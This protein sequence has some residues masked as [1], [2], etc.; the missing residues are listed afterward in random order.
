MADGQDRADIIA[1]P[2]VIFAG[3]LVLGAVISQVWPVGVPVPGW[4]YWLAAP[5]VV[6]PLVIAA[7]AIRAL[8]RAK[9]EVDPRRPTSAIVRDGPFTFTRNPL[10][11][12]LVLLFLGISA[13]AGSLSMMALAVPLALVLDRGVI[14][15]EE[16][17]LEAKFGDE[18]RSYRAG[19]RRWL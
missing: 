14:V 17:Y 4:R 19:V 2:P 8:K 9:T 16:R 15:R 18:Y 10:Y 6:A 12:S 13:C 1:L 5:L 7:L 3:F 11:L